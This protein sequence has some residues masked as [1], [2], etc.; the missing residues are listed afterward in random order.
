ML[1]LDGYLKRIGAS[2]EDD[3]AEVHRAH[4]CGIPFE[5]LDPHM[6]VPVA[7]HPEALERKLV[8]E[9]RGGYCFEQNLLLASALEA[10][11]A[12]VAPLLARVRWGARPGVP[13]PRAH[14]ALRV[15]HGGS[16]WLADVGFGN[17]T[18]LE[19]IPFGRGGP[20]E[21]AG[22]RFRI[23]EDGLE[24]VLQTEVQGE[25][26]DVYG[27]APE[28]APHVDIEMSNWYTSTHPESRFVTGLLVAAT[29][30]DGSRLLLS[31]FG[32]E[33]TLTRR[34]PEGA[35]STP[36]ARDEIASLLAFEFE[37]D[38]F[39]LDAAGRVTRRAAAVR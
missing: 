25:W 34:T 4:A 30:R 38:G 13:L 21:Q 35:V 18:L 23:V 6:G 36:T 15:E 5:N 10:L 1:D 29:R 28:P 24:H 3:M 9:R 2:G 22:W 12:S 7:L 39:A 11:G 37:L 33:L 17:G 19:P 14:L 20:Y 31:D 8:V 27:F 32:G 26:R 16:V